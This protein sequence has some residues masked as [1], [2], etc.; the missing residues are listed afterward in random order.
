M[1]RLMRTIVDSA[2]TALL[3][4]VA[5]VAGIVLRGVSGVFSVPIPIAALVLVGAWVILGYA[6]LVLVAL[7][8][9]FS[10]GLAVDSQP[11]EEGELAPFFG[12]AR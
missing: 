8:F 10:G 12:A 3:V 1:I 7:R 9:P 11:F 5:A 4:V 2:P 6:T